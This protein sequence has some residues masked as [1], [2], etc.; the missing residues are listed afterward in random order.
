[1]ASD[2]GCGSS[3]SETGFPFVGRQREL[4]QVLDVLAHPPAVLLVEGEAGAGKSRLV[5]ET[6]TALAPEGRPVLV[7]LCHPLHEPLA[8]G[9]VVDALGK[10]GPWLPRTA[11]MPPTVGALAPLLPDLAGRLPPVPAVPEGGQAVRHQR[12]QG[13]RSFLEMLGPTVLVVE[14]LHWVDDATRELL[15]LL[16]RDLPAN[17][18]ILLTY[19]AEDIAS[20]GHVLGSAYR[21]PPGTHGATIHL[22]PLAESAVRDMAAAALGHDVAP[23]L[24]HVLY[25]RSEGLPLIAE[26]DL[27]TLSERVRQGAPA[28][29]EVFAADLQHASVP[30]VLREAMSERVANLSPPGAAIVEAAA[31]LAVPSSENLLTQVAGL[32]ADEGSKSLTEALRTFALHE[33]RPTRY[34]FRHVLAQQAVYESIPGPRRQLLHQRALGILRAQTPQPLMQIAHHTLALGDRDG[35]LT[36][37]ESAADQAIEIG[38]AG[39]A[40]TVLH[41]ILAQPR[42]RGDLR[43]RAALALARIATQGVDTVNSERVLARI[44]ADPHLPTTDRGEV[45]LALGMLRVVQAGDRTGYLEIEQASVE[46]AG[47]P[48]RAVRAMTVLAI[49]ERDGAS[50]RAGMWLDRAEEILRRNH[51]EVARAAVRAARLTLLARAGDPSVWPMIA[52]LPRQADDLEILRHTTRALYNVGDLAIELGHDRRAAELL[53]ESLELGRQAGHQYLDFYV[54]IDL[55]RLEALAGRWTGLEQRFAEL[56]AEI[57]DLAM[58]S[59]EEALTLGALAAARGQHDQAL[60]YF[61]RAFDAGE[62]EGQVTILLRAASGEAAVRLAQ[63]RPRDAWT[64]VTSAVSELRATGAWARGTGLVPVAVEAALACEDRSAAQRLVDD[65]AAGLVDKDAPAAAAELQVARGVLLR[66]CDDIAAAESFDR[67]RAAWDDMGRPYERARADE[68]IA[69]A[70]AD[71]DGGQAA[72]RLDRCME[73]YDRLG[74]TSDSARCRRTLREIGWSRPSPRGRRGYGEQLSP[75]EREVA[76]LLAQGLSNPAIAQALFLSPR[77]VEHHVARVLRKLRVTRDQVHSAAQRRY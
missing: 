14:D 4:N 41:D 34:T 28:S 8:L 62:K 53:S 58:E 24:V 48:G 68:R 3:A 63:N 76:D 77:T 54:R 32:E 51:D 49:N 64:S 35:W 33:S 43:S 17:L 22:G 6:V 61:A 46:L 73:E 27:L 67:A 23:H 72:S 55:L 29:A 5:H 50:E 11:D 70:V 37:A 9:P 2:S 30:T 12:I 52:E 19:R 26:E 47:R 38:D 60:T 66:G 75:R 20:S 39:T 45:R 16:A 10:A 40:T 57:P 56:S 25:H 13:V 65:A 31:V 69:G 42:L 18:S 44:L 15:L 74:A 1:M 21:R 71:T 7:G 59:D 36:W